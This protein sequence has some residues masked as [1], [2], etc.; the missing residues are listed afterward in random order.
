MVSYEEIAGIAGVVQ[1]LIVPEES[2]EFEVMVG[3]SLLD[4][5][6]F[7]ISIASGKLETVVNKSKIAMIKYK[8]ETTDNSKG[9]DSLIKLEEIAV[10]TISRTS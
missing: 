6:L 4:E 7:L 10:D 9:K 8:T 5:K 3:R 2:Q 1:V